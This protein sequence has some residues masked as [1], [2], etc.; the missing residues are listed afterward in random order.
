MSAGPVRFL[1]LEEA[2]DAVTTIRTLKPLLTEQDEETLAILM[3]KELV[4]L[5]DTSLHE[6]HDGKLEPLQSI[7][8]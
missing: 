3:D 4:S 7:L 1:A 2:R 8:A 5:L 6:M